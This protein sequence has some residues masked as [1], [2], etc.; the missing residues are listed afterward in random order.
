MTDGNVQ[1]N[2]LTPA[3]ASTTAGHR[4]E[5]PPLQFD[6]NL[7][8]PVLR[9]LLVGKFRID[10][11]KI[12]LKGASGGVSKEFAGPG[13]I[14]QTETE[15]FAITIFV[16]G[17]LPFQDISMS[18][19]VPGTLL[20]SAGAFSLEAT[21]ISGRTWHAGN[22]WMPS[23]R[24]GI[25]GD[26]YIVRASCH[27]LVLQ[28]SS[29]SIEGHSL[30]LWSRD[31]LEFPFPTAGMF[32]PVIEQQQAEEPLGRSYRTIVLADTFQSC[33]FEFATFHHHGNIGLRAVG[34]QPPPEHFGPRVWESML[35]A[36]AG[37]LNWSAIRIASN[38]TEELRIRSPR[39]RATPDGSPPI[40][41]RLYPPPYDTWRI[42]ECYLKY[43]LA[44]PPPAEPKLHPLSS[45]VFSA[46][47]SGGASLEVQSLTLTVAV[48]AVLAEFF[49]ELGKPTAGIQPTLPQSGQ[50]SQF[51]AQS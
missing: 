6:V 22:I 37:P 20:S 48:E 13:Y 18:G 43:V 15:G 51:P 39:A 9:P 45:Q 47:N 34:S 29:C 3:T 50:A 7:D 11:T 41:T 24:R 28:R 44:G 33:G 21:D 10:C 46:R 49:T 31:Q 32:L 16:A 40:L 38:G 17:S 25:G 30:E 35:F 8:P 1:K 5:L 42:F 27:E 23:P 19:G 4:N 12:L 26:G 14:A 36:L 2:S